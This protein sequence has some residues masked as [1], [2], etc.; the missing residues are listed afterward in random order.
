MFQFAFEAALFTLKANA[1][2]KAAALL[3]LQLHPT[4]V[5]RKE[6]A[7][8]AT[9]FPKSSTGDKSPGPPMCGYAAEGWSQ[10]G[11]APMCQPAPEAALYTEKAHAPDKAAASFERQVH[12][13]RGIA[14]M[15]FANHRPSAS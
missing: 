10:D 14:T 3:E 6:A 4:R 13:T 1:P 7:R 9:L 2:D 5:L 12:P 8:S 15:L 11:E